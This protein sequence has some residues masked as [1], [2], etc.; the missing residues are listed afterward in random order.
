MMVGCMKER[1]SSGIRLV[2]LLQVQRFDLTRFLFALF[3]WKTSAPCPSC[4]SKN[5]NDDV[6][7][8]ARST[9]ASLWT[10]NGV[11]FVPR[12]TTSYSS[13]QT[14]HGKDI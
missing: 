1:P 9:F 8:N 2:R 6:F 5:R 13:H 7:S 10:N 4:Q 12:Q 3:T 14:L 11:V